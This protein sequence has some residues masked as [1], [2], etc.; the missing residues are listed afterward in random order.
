MQYQ[1]TA[2]CFYYLSLRHVLASVLD[3]CG[4]F[5]PHPATV[6]LRFIVHLVAKLVSCVYIPT[7]K[8]WVR[9]YIIFFPTAVSKTGHNKSVGL[10]N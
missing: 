3:R 5:R 10:C 7:H 9:Y 4:S 2:Q 8:H 1:L 6:T